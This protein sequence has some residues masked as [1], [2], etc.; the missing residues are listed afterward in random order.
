MDANVNENIELNTNKNNR[1]INKIGKVKI[2]S[3]ERIRNP[4]YCIVILTC[5]MI[6]IPTLVY[7]ILM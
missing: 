2:I 1:F 5:L 7:S 4:N 6:I 3:N